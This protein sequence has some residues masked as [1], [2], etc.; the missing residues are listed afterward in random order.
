MLRLRF[1]LFWAV[2]AM[3][4]LCRPALADGKVFSSGMVNTRIPDQSALIVFNGH[5]ERLVI[6]TTFVGEGKDFAW[7]VP[8]PAMPKVEA[9]TTGLFPTLRMITRPRVIDYEPEWFILPA[10]GL[11]AGILIWIGIITRNWIGV[12]LIFL[13]TLCL[14]SWPLMLGFG[15][16]EEGAAKGPPPGGVQVRE[17][18]VVGAYETA[19][20]SGVEGA[21][22]LDWLNGNGY[23]VPASTRPVLDQYARE[24]WYFVAARLRRESAESAPA[25]PH[26]LSFTFA[27]D[28][29]VY[30]LRL[31]GIENGPL[32]VELF[33]AGG[34]EAAAGS[35][36]R[37]RAA[38]L[39]L[40]R[41]SPYRD[42]W[43]GRYA[44]LPEFDDIVPVAHD[45]LRAYLDGQSA[46][47]VLSARLAPD[48]MK[49]DAYFD[50][51]PLQPYRRILHTHGYAVANAG[52]WAVDGFLAGTLVCAFL[53]RRRAPW[54][55]PP[56]WQIGL[57]VL[58]LVLGAVVLAVIVG[59]FW[60][61]LPR[62]L[63][64]PIMAVV[65]VPF[66]IGCVYQWK[67]FNATREKQAAEGPASKRV[68]WR[69]MAAVLVLTTLVGASEY[70]LC[71]K[72]PAAGYI[73]WSATSEPHYAISEALG[74]FTPPGE[75]AEKLAALRGKVSAILKSL[76]SVEKM[77]AFTGLP[78]REEDSPGNYVVELQDGK[79]TFCF[80]D[81]NGEKVPY[82]SPDKK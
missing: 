35:F 66:I 42:Y 74:D 63:C 28:R 82:W 32:D 15:L 75:P 49:Q 59:C 53:Y 12:A 11:F 79:P 17:R 23:V 50:W 60:G 67:D 54:S 33:V 64:L 13:L 44:S 61:F 2:V 77:N 47:T 56:L 39:L 10:I 73:K 20:I 19:T 72:L 34:K 70:L 27:T 22:I 81:D 25:A 18:A 80:I 31:T 52:T 16:G 48:Q 36:A 14:A 57:A 26:P 71:E 21:G 43:P 4:C 46:L 55:W 41:P 24:K 3:A 8:L 1:S 5:T 6:E 78:I 62:A 45:A 9:A 37:Q 51:Q 38:R 69:A 40:L 30:P 58:G 7:V 76:Q 65:A 68:P 29:A